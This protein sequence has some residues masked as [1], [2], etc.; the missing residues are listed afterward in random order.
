MSTG[1]V[2]GAFRSIPIAAEA[3]GRF[4]AP[5]RPTWGKICSVTD[6]YFGYYGV[7]RNWSGIL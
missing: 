2:T 6:C 4:S 3:V 5:V 7:S 1:D